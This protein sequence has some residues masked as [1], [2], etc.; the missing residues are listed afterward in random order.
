MLFRTRFATAAVAVGLVSGAGLVGTPAA[1]A[2]AVRP[3]GAATATATATVT[4]DRAAAVLARMSLAQRVG[5]LFMVGGPATGVG[6]AA[7]RAV[8]TYH[9]GNVMLTGRSYAGV[10]RTATVSA[11][12]QRLT[13]TAATG[14]V[15]LF[16][17]TDQE[18]GLVQ[19]LNGR[20]FSDMPTALRQGSLSPSSLRQR[21]TSWAWQLRR[22]GVNMNLAPV[23][24]TVPSARSA[25]SNPP[26]GALDREYG[27]TP[28][29]V[30]SRGTAFAQGMDAAG[31]EA[32]VKH[33]PGLGRVRA[34][35]DTTGRVTDTTTTRRDAYVRPF[36]AAVRA[37][38]PFVM[39]SSAYYT[40]IDAKSPAV[41]STKVIK[42][43]LRD[44]L[45]FTGVVISDDLGN[46]RAV[47]R[48]SPG[49]RA[50]KFIRAGG[51]MV[52]TVNAGLLP[53]MYSSVLAEA[54]A[55]PAFRARVD[56]SALRVL[57][58]KQARG[59][60]PAPTAPAALLPTGARILWGSGRLD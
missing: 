18:G 6:P 8:T 38:A 51:D 50:V 36:A 47:T 3:G 7:R 59:L 44:D 24:D 12:L 40:R 54:R 32:S 10:A 52:L 31:V 27:F 41:F 17:A 9:V 49:V 5:Q 34:N 53:A 14:G 57:Q 11:G 21:A 1:G 19:V 25:R 26:I 4:A 55:D 20:G 37:G 46:A 60:L 39:M 42:G 15:P 56:A 2:Q 29:R 43:M 13:T 48:W 30:A 35:T 23:L 16:V 45:G 33:F 28:A 22:A 58:R